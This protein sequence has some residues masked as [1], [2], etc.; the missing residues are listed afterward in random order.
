MR[1]AKRKGTEEGLTLMESLVGIMVIAIVITAITPPLLIAFA[2]RVQNYI[3]SQAMKIAQGEIDRVRLVI[4]KGDYAAG[5]TEKLPPSM[6]TNNFDYLGVGAPTTTT[7]NGTCPLTNVQGSAD[8]RNTWCS[9]DVTGD[10]V[11]DL[12]IQTFRTPAFTTAGN[13]S[14]S[15]YPNGK[16]IAF[17]ITVRAYTRAALTSGN[18]EKSFPRDKTASL[19][20][21]A[22][23]SITLPLVTRYETIVRSDLK[24]SR[25]LYCELN[26]K[27]SNSLS[28][29]N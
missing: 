4:E 20:M 7:P 5:W 11:W 14:T 25:E 27:L 16:P 28:A 17:V 10:G 2:T 12:G 29:C 8:P 15:D 1:S 24:I 6:G 22:G 3:A 21:T 13:P 19:G 23:Q 26:G 9:V 18:L